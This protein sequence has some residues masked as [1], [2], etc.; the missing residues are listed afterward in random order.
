[1]NKLILLLLSLLIT[2]CSDSEQ[3]YFP[4][5]KGVKWQYDVSLINRDGISNQKYILNN[6]G[7]SE[8]NGEPV[9]LKQSFDGTILYYSNSD[10]GIQYLGKADSNNIN[11]NFKEEKKQVIPDKIDVGTV[12]EELTTTKLLQKTGPP[13]KTLFKI[14]AEVPMEVKIESL[15]ETVIV[16]AG[17][18]ENCMKVFMDGFVFKDAGNYVGLTMVSVQQSNWYAPGVGLVKAERLETTEQQALDKGTLLIE[19]AKFESG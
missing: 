16:P 5:E 3:S 11:F 7:E 8:L 15:T 13:Q 19:L 17:K 6:L 12:W 14:I 2:A 4:L 18:F 1:M 9:Y 10:N